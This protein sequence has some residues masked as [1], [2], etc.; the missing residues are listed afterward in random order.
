[1]LI[2]L[3]AASGAA[4]ELPAEFNL[5]GVTAESLKGG[6][7]TGPAVPAIPE[8]SA[9]SVSSAE[10]EA[11]TKAGDYSDSAIPGILMP[12]FA[13]YHSSP[14]AHSVGTPSKPVQF[15]TI[16]GGR[17]AM[18]TNS[19]KK[20][21]EDAY[22]VHVVAVRTFQMSKTAVT[23]EQYAECVLNGWCSEPGTGS[24]CN[25][26]LKDRKFHP[27]N[28]VS[29]TQ[30]NRYVEFKNK[31]RGFE[32]VRLP[33][34]AEWEYAAKSGGRDQ[35]YPWGNEEATCDRAVMADG[36]GAAGCGKNR[37]MPVCSKPYGNTVQGLCDMAGNVRQWVQ[38]TYQRSYS[39]APADGSA[40]EGAGAG[41]VARG[42]SFFTS[43]GSRLRADCRYSYDAI[44]Y[45][46]EIG[47][48]LAR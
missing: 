45:D 44:N 25:W 12:F 23:V 40:F 20:Y 48:R 8:A 21:F 29:W 17:F 4:A 34:E 2:A 9:P 39:G 1:M 13:W 6:E 10:L 31:Q 11:G 36:Q 16:P 47:F 38:D 26:G 32:S 18:G 14:A 19:G 41:R 15:I 27:V 5:A 35:K 33:T 46:Y 37:T 3:G 30:A 28:C 24:Y 42:G 7:M 22:P 43:A